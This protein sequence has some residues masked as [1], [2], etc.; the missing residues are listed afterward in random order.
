M[1]EQIKATL[2]GA[3]LFAEICAF[4]IILCYIGG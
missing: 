4:Y 3:L 1:I 2:A